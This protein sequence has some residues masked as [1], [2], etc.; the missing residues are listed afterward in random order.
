MNKQ[1][2][3]NKQPC[4]RVRP[5]LSAS[6]RLPQQIQNAPRR[7]PHRVRPTGPPL[8]RRQSADDSPGINLQKQ[9]QRECIT[10]CTIQESTQ[11]HI[12]SLL[13]GNLHRKGGP[14]QVPPRVGELRPS[15]QDGRAD[16][17]PTPCWQTE[18][19]FMVA[20]YT[21]INLSWRSAQKYNYTNIPR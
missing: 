20:I 1:S 4:S 14:I 19:I 11:N 15:S 18:A 17:G 7:H 8:S 2:T 12:L 13:S 9:T 10:W 16:T 6:K 3:N 21:S 5:T